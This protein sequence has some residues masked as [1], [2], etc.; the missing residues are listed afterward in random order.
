MEIVFFFLTFIFLA[1][2]HKTAYLNL[3]YIISFECANALGNYAF[4]ALFPLG[5]GPFV[6]FF[7]HSY[8]ISYP[9]PKNLIVQCSNHF[10]T[11]EIVMQSDNITILWSHYLIH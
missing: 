10:H 6:V 1:S 4:I 3:Q 9:K 5:I 7:F 8:S 11:H 2:V